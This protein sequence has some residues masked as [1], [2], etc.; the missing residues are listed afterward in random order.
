MLIILPPSE[1]KRPAPDAGPPVE[2]RE[3]SFPELNPMRERILDALIQTSGQPDAFTRLR[4]GPSLVE[5]VMRNTVLRETPTQP[6]FDV[7]VGPLYG[8]LDPATLTPASRARSRKA[9]VIASSLWGALRPFDRIPSYRLDVC[10][11]LIGCDRLEPVWRTVL[12]TVLADA[13]G[14]RGVVLDLRS[15]GYQAIGVPAIESG[16]R[17]T[18]RVLPEAG[19][20]S[21]GNVIAKRIR[22]QIAR[23]LLDVGSDPSTPDDLADVLSDRWPTRLDPPEGPTQPWTLRLRPPD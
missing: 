5:D 1:S 14:P 8:G 7:Y 19:A 9:V 21:V 23:H 13:A 10:S 4:V 11:R 12:P 18:I 6:A 2:L 16:R 20:R 17:V 15:P 22:G 3:L